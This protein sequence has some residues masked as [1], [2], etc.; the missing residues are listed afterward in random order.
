M[1]MIRKFVTPEREISH[2]GVNLICSE[3]NTPRFNP[4]LPPRIS[5][6]LEGK[7]T[8]SP[9]LFSPFCAQQNSC[10]GEREDKHD[11]SSLLDRA[12]TFA[13][14]RS[15]ELKLES[16]EEG[17]RPSPPPGLRPGWLRVRF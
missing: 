12:C 13:S 16:P 7:G 8:I 15:T 6:H 1:P 4:Q 9:S 3:S 10:C 17:T 11:D 14:R 2:L 5:L